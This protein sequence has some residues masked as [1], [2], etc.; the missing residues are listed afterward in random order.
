MTDGRS[1]SLGVKPALI[2]AASCLA[3][4]GIAAQVGNFRLA[5]V[6]TV[7][8]YVTAVDA[9]QSSLGYANSAGGPVLGTYDVSALSVWA[10]GAHG[11]WQMVGRRVAG[12]TPTCIPPGSYGAKVE[13]TLSRAVMGSGDVL[14][15]VAKLRCLEPPSEQSISPLRG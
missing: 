5:R 13:L 4:L 11:Q 9:D 10:D 7:Q 1:R 8:I 3:L 2:G 12:G 14:D 6:E 15:H